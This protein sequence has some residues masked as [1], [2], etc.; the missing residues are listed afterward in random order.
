[1]LSEKMVKNVSNNDQLANNR[2]ESIITTLRKY[3]K[4]FEEVAYYERQIGL[5]SNTG[6]KKEINERIE[7]LLAIINNLKS[8]SVANQNFLTQELN[9]SIG[10]FWVVYI[11]I[12][13]FLSV[14]I[15]KRFTKRI[16]ILSD[17]INFFVNANFTVRLELGPSK[18]NDEVGRL[19]NN[20]I[21]ME[22]EIVEYI[23]LFKEKVD[24]KT[25]ELSYINQEI[26]LKNMELEAQK[27][28]TD[29]KNKDL[30]DGI[31]YGWRIQRAL[32]P[33]NEK[34]IKNLGDGFM[35]FLPKD[36]VS[37]DIYW[38][39]I[40]KNKQEGEE[41]LFSV[42]DCTGHGV[43]GAFMSILAVNAINLG[44]NKK[45]NSPAAL[46]QSHERLCL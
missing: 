3:R 38:T 21:K 23:E 46:L 30:L 37:G 19:W 41:N 25:L 29:R 36:I 43:P 35:F 2:K 8:Y 42:I 28:E 14:G 31:R 17:R 11:I 45:E 16:K 33:S 15:A 12:S 39:Q 5:K 18:R 26:E 1:M 24:E 34:L 13:I 9:Y 27:E 44:F 20:F 10:F 40:V 4:L 6:L 22:K 32:I 7:S